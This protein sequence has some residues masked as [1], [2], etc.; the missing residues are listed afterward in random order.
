MANTTPTNASTSSA[1]KA[2]ASS[3]AELMAS[4]KTSFKTFHKGDLVKGHITKLTKSEILVDLEAKSIAIVLEKDKT[5]LNTIMSTLKVGDEVEVSILSP[6]SE[7][8]HPI[9]SLRRFL[10]LAIWSELEEAQKEEKQIEVTVTDVT[11]GGVVAVTHNGVSGFLPNSH[12]AGGEQLNP[13]KKIKVKV[14]ELSR[15]DNKLVFSQ[16]TTISAADFEAAIKAFKKNAKV[17]VTIANITAFGIFVSIPVPG[18]E[19]TL[20]GLIHI[21]EIAWEKVEDINQL[22]ASGQKVEAVVIGFDNNARRVDLSIK[23]LTADPFDAIAEKYPIDTK[24]SAVVT[25][26][27]DTGVFLELGEGVE[28]LIKKDKVPANVTYTEG[29]KVNATVSELDRKRQRVILVPVL[30]EKPIGYR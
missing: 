6:E 9:V 18:K 2:P 19:L 5:L 10:S 14:L 21:S 3:M 24:V 17:E 27:D 29:Q 22:Y 30:L 12:I 23:R 8:G 4:Y 26:I 15:K 1:R 13:N 11:K 16:K 28:G 20:D 7:S 25:T